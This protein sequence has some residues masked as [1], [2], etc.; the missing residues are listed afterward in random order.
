MGE[1][2]SREQSPPD[3]QTDEPTTITTNH[4]NNKRQHDSSEIV[5]VLARQSPNPEESVPQQPVSTTT[6]ST[7]SPT[8]SQRI[9]RTVD[10]ERVCKVCGDKARARN[11]DVF[12]CESCKTFFRR[13]AHKTQKTCQFEGICEMTVNTRRFCSTCRLRKCFDTGMK[14]DMILDEAERQARMD[15]IRSNRQ[16]RQEQMVGKKDDGCPSRDKTPRPLPSPDSEAIDLLLQSDTF[17]QPDTLLEPDTA[18]AVES[19]LSDLSR[20]EPLDIQHLEQGN[21]HNTDSQ[22]AGSFGQSFQLGD[23][24]NA[25]EHLNGENADVIPQ[26]LQYDDSDAFNAFLQEQ[27]PLVS[28]DEGYAEQWESFLDGCPDS[29]Q[30]DLLWTQ[31]MPGSENETVS[32]AVVDGGHVP[33]TL[34]MGV[35][36][37]V[38]STD[39]ELINPGTSFDASFVHQQR[40][41]LFAPT[42]PASS[43][44]AVSAT[45]SSHDE[46]SISAAPDPGPSVAGSKTLVS[47]SADSYITGTGAHTVSTAISSKSAVSTDHQ[48][49]RPKGLSSTD[50]PVSGQMRGCDKGNEERGGCPFVPVTPAM[51][52][53]D[54]QLYWKLTS[55]EEAVITQLTVAFQEEFV[56]SRTSVEDALV[57]QLDTLSLKETMSV[58]GAFAPKLIAFLKRTPDFRSL[59]VYDQ[60]ATLK[61]NAMQSLVVLSAF[62]YSVDRQAWFEYIGFVSVEAFARVLQNESVV[63]RMGDLCGRLKSALKEDHSLYMLLVCSIFFD[64]LTPNVSDRQSVNFF[65]DKYTLLL[66]HYLDSKFSYMFSSQYQAFLQDCLA[67]SKTLAADMTTLLATWKDLFEPLIVEL[68]NF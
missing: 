25:D 67:Q 45:V 63:K 60:Q 44:H 6:T 11:F 23:T 64:P 49:N 40:A 46:S 36:T 32:S 29:G 1:I 51:L 55:E 31:R 21:T 27:G 13:N 7:T 43:A 35:T 57:V 3:H 19:L 56:P 42:C 65:R 47:G 14:A 68:L 61:A 9:H 66:K 5:A 26:C 41:V 33:F 24:Q 58:M 54:P 52:P 39:Y 48:E 53:S 8:T 10:G 16:K 22:N 17:L 34:S 15:K 12:S 28:P 62:L 30:S 59:D 50:I 20:I 18:L 37:D 38:L 4:E 2:H